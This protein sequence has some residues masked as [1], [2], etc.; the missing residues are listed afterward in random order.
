MKRIKLLILLILGLTFTNVDAAQLYELIPVDTPATIETEHFIYKDFYY[1][2]N[3][4]Q[5]EGL[6]SNHVIFPIIENKTKEEIPVSI[7]FGVFNKDKENIGTINYCSTKDKYTFATKTI[8]PESEVAYSIPVMQMDLADGADIKDVAYISVYDE[9]I[10]CSNVNSI[11]DEGKT[12]EDL[13]KDSDNPHAKVD[14]NTKYFV[15]I[16]AGAFGLLILVLIIKRLV[17]GG[18]TQQDLI[19]EQYQNITPHTEPVTEAV[20]TPPTVPITQP[21]TQP[22]ENSDLMN[23]FK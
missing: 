17:T 12:I 18:K 19:R 21:V 1:N 6:N 22:P 23:M 2:N 8:G 3:Q 9:N 7:S 5:A 10:K 16:V 15:Y 13:Q 11:N 4:M 20:T 14:K